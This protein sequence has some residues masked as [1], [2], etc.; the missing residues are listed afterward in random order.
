[1]PLFHL[2][3]FLFLSFLLSGVTLFGDPNWRG[4]FL[5]L[6]LFSF[7]PATF[8]VYVVTGFAKT[9]AIGL[10]IG[11]DGRPKEAPWWFWLRNFGFFLPA[12]LALLIYLFIPANPWHAMPGRGSGYSSFRRQPFFGLFR[13]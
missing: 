4:H 8:F 12:S 9:G 3:T 6:I 11:L 1:M 7:I 2:H 10:A 13:D 5:R